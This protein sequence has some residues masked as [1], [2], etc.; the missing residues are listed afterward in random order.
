MLQA[1]VQFGLRA[2]LVDFLL[3]FLPLRFLRFLAQR[4]FLR[5]LFLLRWLLLLL[6]GFGFLGLPD[7]LGFLLH[8]VREEAFAEVVHLPFRAEIVFTRPGDELGLLRGADL[9]RLGE[10][11]PRLG[12]LL[13]DR[14]LLHLLCRLRLLF[15]HAHASS[16][17]FFVM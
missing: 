3:G 10:R 13:R 6:C 1:V 16:P 11:L 8:H 5:R 15:G 12:G 17:A 7:G 4:F 2:G 9:G 14:G